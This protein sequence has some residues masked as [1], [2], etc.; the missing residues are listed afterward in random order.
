MRYT[1]I[2]FYSD[3]PGAYVYLVGPNGPE[4]DGNTYRGQTSEDKSV[5]G[6]NGGMI[7]S[8][9]SARCTLDFVFKKRGYKPTTYHVDVPLKYESE[10]EAEQHEQKVVVVLDTE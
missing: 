9:R 1:R 5:G 7:L 3:P 2:D 6:A 4:G 8:N 10:S